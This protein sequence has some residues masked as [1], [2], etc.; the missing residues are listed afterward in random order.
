MSDPGAA[1]ARGVLSILCALLLCAGCGDRA[2]APPPALDATSCASLAEPGGTA[3][4]IDQGAQQALGSPL[5]AHCLLHGVLEP[6]VGERGVAYGTGFELRLPVPWNGR[7]F[8][9]GGSGSDGVVATAFGVTGGHSALGQGFAVVTTDSGHE[10]NDQTFGV[11]PQA[12]IDYGYRALDLV[13]RHAKAVIARAYGRGPER[14]YLVGCSNGGRQGFLATQRFPD[15]FDGV[16]AGSPAFDVT[17]ASV[18]AAWNTQAVA[19]IAHT[20]DATGHPYLPATFSDADLQLLVSGVL[21]RCDA[22]DGLADGII[23]DLRGCDFDPGALVCAGAKTASCLDAGQVAALRKIFGGVHDSSG[24]P[25]YTGFFY[26]AGLADPSPIGSLR[27]WTLGS[28]SVATNTSS[29]VNL[30]AGLLSLVF[31]TPPVETP[32]LVAFMLGFDFD[33]DVAKLLATSPPFDESG[34]E[35]M[36]ATSTDLSTFRARGGKLIA[37]AG[38]SD[39]VFS[40]QDVMRWFDD[41]DAANAGAAADFARLFVVPGMGHCA[42]GPSTDSFDAFDALIDWVEHDVAPQ[43]IVATASKASPFPGRTRPLCPYP[44][45]TRYLGSGSIDSAESF[46]CR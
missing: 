34:T 39:G 11:D 13:T 37:Y 31:T 16:L 8:F 43:R 25:L 30:V 23:D 14:S 28:A 32:D 18:A 4:W 2:A 26:D 24:T 6:R 15:E 21:A 12:R 3:E 5:P 44:L 40:V 10:S 38:A 22:N 9:Q 1:A 36:N 20:V 41:L 19:A 17:R 46:D 33:R 7:F 29:D 45:Q 42:G 35:F 27:G